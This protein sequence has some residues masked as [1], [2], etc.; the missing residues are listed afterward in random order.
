M[1]TRVALVLLARVHGVAGRPSTWSAIATAAFAL[2]LVGVLASVALGAPRVVR[3]VVYERGTTKP[4]AGASVLTDRGAI[5]VSDLDGYFTIEVAD[6]DRELTIA[7]T[8]Y[9]TRSVRI[10]KTG[11]RLS[12]DLEPARGA[13]VIEV[14]GKAPEETKPLSYQLTADEIRV[15]PGAGNDILRA[16]QALPGV[17][18]IPYSF[19]GLVLRGMSPRDSSVILDGVEVPL[20]FHFGGVTSFYPGGM[21]ADLALTSGGFDASHGRAQGGLISLTTREPRTD[22][23]R[24]GGSIG[25]LD[26]SVQIEG[27]LPKQGGLIAGLRRSYFDTIVA[28]F[29]DEDTPLPSYWDFQLRT[30]WGEPRAEVK[31]TPMIFGSIDRVASSEVSVTSSFVRAAAPMHRHWGRLGLHIVPWIGWNELKFSDITEGQTFARPTY[32][33]GVRAE[34][35]RDWSWGHWRGGAELSGGYLAQTQINTAGSDGPQELTGDSTIAW[36]DVALWTEVRYH[37]PEERF[38]IKPGVRVEVYGLTTGTPQR[39]SSPSVGTIGAPAG[40]QIV[41]DPRLNISQR[42]TDETTFRQAIGR[43]H[44]PPTPGDVDPVN[45]NP[46]LDS[47][48]VD[49]MSLGIETTFPHEIFASLTSFYHYGR[50]M[51]LRLRNPRPGSDAPEPNLGGLGPTFELLLEKQLGFAIYRESIG[52]A[53]TAGVEVLLKRSSGNLFTM[54][55][56]TL[57]LAQR[58][59]DPRSRDI[60]RSGVWRPFELDQRHNLQVAISR[61]WEKWRLGAR[62]QVVSGNPYSPSQLTP[63]GD[64]VQTPWAGRLPTFVSLDLR[65]DRRWRRCWGDINLYVDIQNALDYDNVEGRE[66]DFDLGTDGDIPGLPIIPFIGVEFLPLL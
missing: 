36:T 23:W 59:E 26:S 39:S 42:V 25:L 60:P 47:S 50:D 33:G 34:L 12:I 18:R 24:V 22:H 38:A 10:P 15:I 63:S 48:Y 53:R 8:G 13:E 66:F 61:R 19:G 28:P 65:V 11:E 37:T 55:A 20:A 1:V 46:G 35:V 21:L 43:Y 51:G 64:V 29:V 16:V 5:A 54:L 30:S 9:A 7:A 49:Q 3:G 27:P 44:Q 57:S 58:T 32:P 6:A 31:V 40:P 4:I 17:A 41:V 52:R 62:L 45:G 2:A 56:Y 14:S